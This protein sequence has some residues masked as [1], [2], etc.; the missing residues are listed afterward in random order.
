MAQWGGS[1]HWPEQHP[2]LAGGSADH[3]S[4][5]VF[6]RWHCPGGGGFG[7]GGGEGEGG[8]EGLGG[9]FGGEGGGLGDG[10]GEG[11]YGSTQRSAQS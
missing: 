11:G 3:M 7:G 8:G 4:H 6:W 5:G 10:G 2:P 1:T 9:G